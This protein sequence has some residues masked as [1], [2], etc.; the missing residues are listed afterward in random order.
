MKK[1]ISFLLALATLLSIA[2]CGEVPPETTTAPTTP[3]TSAATPGATTAP[4]DPTEATEPEI[5]LP[6]VPISIDPDAIILT[7]TQQEQALIDAAL[8]RTV[9]ID[10]TNYRYYGTYN[11]YIILYRGVIEYGERPLRIGDYYFVDREQDFRLYAIYNGEALMLSDVFA[12]G[13]ITQEQL[14]EIYEIH[15]SYHDSYVY[16]RDVLYAEDHMANEHDAIAL[17]EKAAAEI[18]QVYF[19]AQ[20]IHPDIDGDK[21][22]YYGMSGD[23]HILFQAQ[24]AGEDTAV[25]LSYYTFRHTGAYTIWVIREGSMVTLEEAYAQQLIS[26]GQLEGILDVHLD[27]YSE[28]KQQQWA[29]EDWLKTGPSDVVNYLSGTWQLEYFYSATGQITQADDCLAKLVFHADGTGEMEY[30][31]VQWGVYWRITTGHE[32]WVTVDVEDYYGSYLARQVFYSIEQDAETRNKLYYKLSDGSY[33]VLRRCASSE[34][35]EQEYWPAEI[36]D[37]M[38]TWVLETEGESSIVSTDF[39]LQ[40]RPDGTGYEILD[41][42]V[43]PITW[44]STENIPWNSQAFSID[45]PQIR[46]IAEGATDYKYVY[47]ETNPEYDYFGKVIYGDSYGYAIP[48]KRLSNTYEPDE[49][50]QAEASISFTDTAQDILGTWSVDYYEANGEQVS[51][52]SMQIQ[53]L[54]DGTG[55]YTRLGAQHQFTWQQTEQTQTSCAFRLL[56]ESSAQ[57]QT[58]YTYS[59]RYVTD[60][61]DGRYHKLVHAIDD[62]YDVVLKKIAGPEDAAAAYRSGAEAALNA[63][64]DTLSV[65]MDQIDRWTCDFAPNAAE[66]SVTVNYGDTHYDF[67]ISAADLTVLSAETYCAEGLSET[68]ARDLAFRY[69]GESL[70]DAYSLQVTN[71]QYMG[72]ELPCWRVSARCQE[73]IYYMTLDYYGKFRG[74]TIYLNSDRLA[75]FEGSDI[76]WQAARDAALDFLGLELED[77]TQL[78]FMYFYTANVDL[79]VYELYVNDIYCEVLAANGVFYSDGYFSAVGILTL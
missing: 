57:D 1:F 56:W 55:Y 72:E 62:N 33:A 61:A 13:G 15:K 11:D 71:L 16:S 47:I 78:S 44:W 70:E 46:Y 28:E 14:T 64:L 59:L 74:I 27:Y 76:S 51:G 35:S 34:A 48:L 19:A 41:D 36:L 25:T 37:M 45:G 29:N 75:S 7:P 18:D 77:M 67:R 5:V 12:D 58:Y 52:E 63:A 73:V 79:P 30:G 9:D 22:R 6:S 21:I 32:G 69:L 3:S 54:A 26:D 10:L 23:C 31:G 40:F 24:E 39:E 42:V 50:A 4:T 65:T 49:P 43:R 66:Y 68:Q 8:G 60:G 20:G 38:G 2:A 17:T 53:F